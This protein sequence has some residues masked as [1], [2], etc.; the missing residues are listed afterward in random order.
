MLRNCASN[1]HRMMEKIWDTNGGLN[2]RTIL[3]R[4]IVSNYGL[5]SRPLEISRARRRQEDDEA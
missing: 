2:M 5:D 4:Y 3:T 1:V